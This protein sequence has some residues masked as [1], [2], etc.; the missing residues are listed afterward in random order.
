MECINLDNDWRNRARSFETR[1]VMN[2][3]EAK[4]RW[5]YF[6]A[7]EGINVSVHYGFQ[8][9][10]SESTTE[11]QESALTYEMSEGIKFGGI[12]ET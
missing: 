4:V 8:S 6:A 3:G 9:S 2:I 12:T 1:K 10:S 5:V 7:T 11:T